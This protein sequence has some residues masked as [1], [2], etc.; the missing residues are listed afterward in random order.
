MTDYRVIARRL[1]RPT[2][3]QLDDFAKHVC[4]AHSWYKHLPPDLPGVPFAFYLDPNAGCDL[5]IGPK[6]TAIY[7][8]RTQSSHLFHYSALL[9]QDHRERLGYLEFASAAGRWILRGDSNGHVLC[10]RPL[11]L[12]VHV[13]AALRRSPLSGLRHMIRDRVLEKIPDDVRTGASVLKSYSP[14]TDCVSEQGWLSVPEAISSAGT[15]ELTAVIHPLS[16]HV[17]LWQE[18][19]CSQGAPDF[20]WPEE[21]GGRA[22]AERLRTIAQNAPDEA[23]KLIDD[24]LEPERERQRRQMVKAMASML[25]AVYD[26]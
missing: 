9:T 21:S 22:V 20:E 12:A 19:L 2:S 24:L 4:Q 8:E 5:M 15:V 14:P 23:E 11:G 26:A 7:R 1:P 16:S 10:T 17:S 6:G 18:R 13:G 3:R 25:R